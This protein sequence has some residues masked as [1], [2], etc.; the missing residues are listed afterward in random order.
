[1]VKSSR[2]FFHLRELVAAVAEKTNLEQGSRDIS[3]TRIWIA[4]L[5]CPAND[6]KGKNG[7]GIEKIY[8]V[9]EKAEHVLVLDSCL[10]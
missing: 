6:G 4:T 3:A 2:K 1:M 10:I 7:K 8:N 9:Y 5:C